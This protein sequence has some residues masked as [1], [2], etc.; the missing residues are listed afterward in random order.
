MEVVHT[1][2]SIKDVSSKYLQDNGSS[3]WLLLLLLLKTGTSSC[4][5]SL[6]G[7]TRGRFGTSMVSIGRVLRFKH[8][9][10]TVWADRSLVL[11]FHHGMLCRRIGH[12]YSSFSTLFH[13]VGICYSVASCLQ[14]HFASLRSVAVGNQAFHACLRVQ[15]VLRV[16]RLRDALGFRF[17]FV[18]CQLVPLFLV[19]SCLLW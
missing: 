14:L 18:T 15:L 1:W 12:E 19:R 9:C 7:I 10:A 8:P 6:M 11:L 13:V 4:K 16:V 2:L 3:M 17:Y 5:R